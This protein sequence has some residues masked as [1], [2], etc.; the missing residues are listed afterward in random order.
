MGFCK[1]VT[2]ICLQSDKCDL[3]QREG[4]VLIVTDI[5]WAQ[6]VAETVGIRELYAEYV[7]IDVAVLQVIRCSN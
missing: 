2:T 1:Y 5:C 7:H 4:R 6:K 3:V